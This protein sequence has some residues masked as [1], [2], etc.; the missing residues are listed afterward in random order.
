[1]RSGQSDARTT[2][3]KPILSVGA[4]TVVLAVG[5]AGCG[6][7]SGPHGQMAKGKIDPRLG[8][9][10]SPR[11]VADG[12]PVPKGGGRVMVGKPYVI[13][14]KKY[15]PRELDPGYTR[16]G[17]ASWYGTAFHGRRTANGE[18][19]DRAS[20]TAAHPTM[21]LPSYARLTS[22]SSG[23]SIVV[24]VNDRGP[25]HSSRILDMSQR[26][27][28]LL[29]VKRAGVAKIKVQYV[30]P[31]PLEG[32]DTPYL[33]ASYHGPADVAPERSNTMLAAAE[34]LPGVR[35]VLGV[36][37]K[38]P[39][40]APKPQATPPAAAPAP[41][42][43]ASAAEA[44]RGRPAPA[45]SVLP[46]P[47]PVE[48]FSYVSIASADPA[49][50]VVDAPVR[51][52]VAEAA[53]VTASVQRLS[54]TVPDAASARQ[55]T[56][57]FGNMVLPPLPPQVSGY[58]ADRVNKAYAAVGDVSGGVGLGDLAR[59]L[60]DA[61]PKAADAAPAI[62]LGVFANADNAAR[63]A[64]ALAGVGTTVSEEVEVG[65]RSMQLLRLRALK[66]SADEALEAAL[67]AG[68]DGARLIR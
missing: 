16:V 19:F 24:R 9:A 52:A 10:P 4:M 22:L 47:R 17:L 28:E 66:V 45:F 33:L 21:P 46:P 3:T 61:S 44:T 29:G 13:A 34:G 2:R 6:T 5:L 63:L 37:G 68:A 7:M 25:Y 41:V 50:F 67:A 55:P 8:V 30:G 59:K 32:D 15:T 60:R 14:G 51:V 18:I 23:R 38:G 1:M 48:T 35:Q 11:V 53:P 36:F 49:D 20:I 27:A 57:I 56:V 65:G 26:T 42:A 62:R 54:Y 58:A 43:V 64:A 12:E 40:A 39:D 31:A